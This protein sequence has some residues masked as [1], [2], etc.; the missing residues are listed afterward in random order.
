M[1]RE[2]RATPFAT[3]H[4]GR[5]SVAAVFA[6]LSLVLTMF[7]PMMPHA[8]A[9]DWSAPTTVYIPETGHTLDQLFLDM[10]RNGGGAAAYGNPITSEI[11]QQDGHVVQYLEYAR[12]EYWPEGDADGNTAF[13]ANIGQELRPIAVQRSVAGLSTPKQGAA[14]EATKFQQAWLPVKATDDILAS[15]SILY[16]SETSHTVAGDFW[17]YWDSVGGA[18]YLGNPL[19]EQYTLNG[20]TYQVFEKGQIAQAKDGTLSLVPVGKLL[21]DKY[22]LDQKQVAQGDIPTYDEALFISPEPETPQ[23]ADA[24]DAPTDGLWVDVNLSTQYMVVYQ[25]NTPVLESYVSTGRPGFDTPTGTFSV[26]DMLPSQTMEGVLGGEYYNVPDVPDVM[27][28]TEGGHALHGTYWHNNFGSV[29]SHGCVNL[30]MDVADWLYANAYIGMP[31][32]I[33]Y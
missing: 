6:A 5:A 12:F 9:D 29:M 19:T 15:D 8:S 26:I 20:I 4:V 25:G 11:T 16:V 32:V 27:Y 28:F 2:N 31:V 1:P 24:T 22:K 21:A 13:I 14:S 30:P 7:L 17:N 3:R 18:G 10:W 23:I 33:H